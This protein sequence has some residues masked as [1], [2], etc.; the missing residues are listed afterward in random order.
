M[1]DDESPGAG[2]AHLSR[3]ISEM[4]AKPEKRDFTGIV[5]TGIAAFV[6]GFEL[7]DIF[8]LDKTPDQ[9]KEITTTANLCRWE[10]VCSDYPKTR[11]VCATAG[12]FDKCMSIKLGTRDDYD[13][14]QSVC[15]NDGGMKMPSSKL[16]GW[17]Q[18]LIA[19]LKY[20][21]ITER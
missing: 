21:R 4:K 16:P 11:D 12:S 17:T 10:N 5:W 1:D 18:C 13:T 8:V 3:T 7:L 19:R 9:V 6:V 20:W 2:F 15:T 14:A